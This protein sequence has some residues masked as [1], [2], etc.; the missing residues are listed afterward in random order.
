MPL[1]TICSLGALT[2]VPCVP[3]TAMYLFRDGRD[4]QAPRTHLGRTGGKPC[5]PVKEQ[6]CSAPTRL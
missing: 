2:C 5:S 4:R 3:D 1:A 6:D